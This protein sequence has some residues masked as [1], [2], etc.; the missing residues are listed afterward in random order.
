[1]RHAAPLSF[2]ENDRPSRDRAWRHLLVTTIPTALFAAAYVLTIGLVAN[3]FV[4]EIG[5]T[6]WRA[7]WRDVSSSWALWSTLWFFGTFFPAWMVFSCYGFWLR[8]VGYDAPL[9]RPLE[10][11]ITAAI[12]LMPWW[13]PLAMVRHP[14]LL[15]RHYKR[16]FRGETLEFSE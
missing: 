3:H 10:T 8:R 2:D 12:L 14:R 9:P 11:A 7:P 1:V 5:P 16:R 6:S 15:L 13:W 4:E